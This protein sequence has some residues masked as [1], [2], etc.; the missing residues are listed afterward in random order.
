MSFQSGNLRRFM[1][2]ISRGGVFVDP[3]TLTF[4]LHK[5]GALI[6]TATWP[7]DVVRESLGS[8]SYTYLFP[9]DDTNRIWVPAWRAVGG[10]PDV[11]CYRSYPIEVLRSS[12]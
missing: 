7:G 1:V 4:T 3:D 11:T 9:I 12:P 5:A 6:L 10:S 8:F 2:E